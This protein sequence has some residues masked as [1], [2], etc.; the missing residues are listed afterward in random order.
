MKRRRNRLSAPFLAGAAILATGMTGCIGP[1]DGST[2]RAVKPALDEIL[3]QYVEYVN[4]DPTLTD[5]YK[6]SRAQSAR[7]VKLN[8]DKAAELA[9]PQ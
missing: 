8:I 2:A 7:L 3:P 9:A 1:A 6:T 4:A 5:Y